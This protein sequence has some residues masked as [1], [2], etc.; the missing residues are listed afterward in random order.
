[1]GTRLRH[2]NGN[3]LSELEMLIESRPYNI[4]IKSITYKPNGEWYIHFTILDNVVF[5][6]QNDPSVNL[7]I[8]SIENNKPKRKKTGEL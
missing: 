2:I 8:A 1:M 4:E 7:S 5:N 3:N 6:A